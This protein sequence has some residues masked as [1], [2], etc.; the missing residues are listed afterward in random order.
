VVADQR[1]LQNGLRSREF[2]HYILGTLVLF[3]DDQVDLTV[4]KESYRKA[5]AN[6]VLRALGM[7]GA[8]SVVG[9]FMKQ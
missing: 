7:V 4:G 1:A 9:C 3:P 5:L 6:A 2:H 8:L